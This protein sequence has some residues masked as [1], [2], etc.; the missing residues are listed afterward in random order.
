[1][2]NLRSLHYILKVSCFSIFAYFHMDGWRMVMREIYE[3]GQDEV[4]QSDVEMEHN[5]KV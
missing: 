5:G 4:S 2:T 1:M 3:F